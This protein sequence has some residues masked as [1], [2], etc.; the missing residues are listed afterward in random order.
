MVLLP[1]LADSVPAVGTLVLPVLD[2]D[3]MGRGMI[4]PCEQQLAFGGRRVEELLLKLRAWGC[5]VFFTGPEKVHLR[6]VWFQSK[7]DR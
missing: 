2:Q 5:V 1:F 6:C 3:P 7:G 4:I